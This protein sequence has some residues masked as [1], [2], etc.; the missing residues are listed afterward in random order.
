MIKTQINN[1]IL[2]RRSPFLAFFVSVFIYFAFFGNYVLFYQEKFSLFIFSSD[3]LKENLHQPGGFLIWLGKLLSAFFYHSFTGA[4]II[5]AILSL[6]VYYLSEILKFQSRKNAI[7]PSIVAG[8]ILFYVQTDY[9]FF[10]FNILGLLLQL[11]IFYISIKY[12]SLL[13]GWIPLLFGPLLYFATGGFAWIFMILFSLW[14]AVKKGN[15]KW[16]KLLL[17]WSI[18]YLTFYISKEYLFFQTNL[19]LLTFPFTELN[20]GMHHT[21]FLSL[22]GG[23]SLL[24]VLL[25]LDRIPE[26]ITLTQPA[27]FLITS[28]V[29]MVFMGALSYIRYDKKTS[30]YFH[31][32]KLF[33]Q[34]KFNEIIAFNTKYTPTNQLTIFLNNIALCETNQLNDKLFS[35]PQDAE[36]GTLYL[37]WEMMGEVL[38]RGGYFYYSVGMINEAHRWAFENMVMKGHTPEGLKMLIKTELINGNYKVAS[39]YIGLLKKTIYYRSE[40]LKYEKL[41]FND[42]ALNEDPELGEK[43]KIRLHTDFFAITDDPYINLGRIL[44][45]DSLNRK[46]FDYM[47]AIQMIKKNYEGIA[48]LLPRFSTLGYRQFPVNVEEAAT[49]L[50]VLNDGRLPDL[51]GIHISSN[52]TNRWN[53]YLTVFQQYGTN[54]K[55]S[56]PALKRQ[57]GTTFWYWAFYR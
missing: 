5:A 38:R 13:K 56:E 47:M 18:G 20:S 8:M 9:Q 10:L 1:S 35:F 25:A 49:A 46:A 31:V 34:K 52:T 21:I 27:Q 42:S 26:R 23:L 45:T 14:L 44:I 11:I 16:I 6:T 7:I 12:L 41:L 28:V 3:F 57:F 48:T 17:L 15:D 19:I 40:A 33:Y 50:S 37:K 22:C 2:Y 53:Q 51:G 29:I 32:E 54:P 36:G 43:R 30:N 39:R 55:A 4:L 24:P